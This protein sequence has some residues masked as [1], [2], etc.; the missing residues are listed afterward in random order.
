MMDYI[1]HTVGKNGADPAGLHV[2][3]TDGSLYHASFVPGPDFDATAK[4]W[5]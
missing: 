4:S 5:Y 2:A 3:L 1:R